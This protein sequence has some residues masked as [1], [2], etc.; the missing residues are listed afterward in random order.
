M[1]KTFLIALAVSAGIA[2]QAWAQVG[3]PD[4]VHITTQPNVDRNV[5][6]VP[7]PVPTTKLG[8]LNISLKN[9]FQAYSK[10]GRWGIQ[11]KPSD[12]RILNGTVVWDNL[13]Y[14]YADAVDCSGTVTYTSNTRQINNATIIGAINKALSWPV[15]KGAGGLNDPTVLGGPLVATASLYQG[16][17]R[18]TAK[19]VVVNYDNGRYLPPYP[20][21]EDYVGDETTSFDTAVWNAPWFLAGKPDI[22]QP[23]GTIIPL[24]WPNQNYISWGK[25]W[26]N[27]ENEFSPQQWVGA[28]VFIIDP[29]NANLNLRCFD[30]TPFF[31]LE[32]SYC[33]YCWDTMDRVTDGTIIF[34]TSQSTPPCASGTFSC[35]LKGSGTTKLYWTVKFDNVMGGWEDDANAPNL[36]LSYGL[37]NGSLYYDDI[38]GWN[39]AN[40]DTF[41]WKLDDTD[42]PGSAFALG[43]TVS[44]IATYPWKFKVLSDGATWPMGKYSMSASGYGFSPMCGLYSGPVS[45]T[46]YDRANKLFGGVWCL[47]P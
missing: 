22:S 25:L 11:V 8:L 1:K 2:G 24:N 9:T 7:T 26:L 28:R 29:G 35:G 15:G 23:D 32:E 16:Q 45:M 27:N 37:K 30:V 43:F 6:G 39:G 13:S 10:S 34:G 14:T 44:G 40:G 38:V 21:T 31:A 20:P 33:Y 5:G 3:W 12:P 19:I 42:E 18:T 36:I 4:A 47:A 41:G 46:E 17:F